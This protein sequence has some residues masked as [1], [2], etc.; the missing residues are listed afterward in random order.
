MRSA[1]VAL[2]QALQGGKVLEPV[3]AAHISP[4]CALDFASLY[5][6]IIMAH[7]LSY[8][9]LVRQDPRQHPA[10]AGQRVLSKLPV[11]HFNLDG[12]SDAQGTSDGKHPSPGV[13]ACFWRKGALGAE[14]GVLV[15]IVRRLVESRE[16]TLAL[17]REEIQQDV[18]VILHHR[19][20]AYKKSCNAM[21][22][23]VGSC[24]GKD[25]L[26]C[27]ALAATITAIGRELLAHTIT[28]IQQ[29]YSVAN[30]FH[31]D[32][33]VVYGDTDSVMVDFKLDSAWQ[34][35]ASSEEGCCRGCSSLPASRQC[36]KGECSRGTCD[37]IARAFA[38]GTQAAHLVTETLPT[39]ICLR[40][41]K[42]YSPLFLFEK[43]YYA[44]R[45]YTHDIH[46]AQNEVEVKG[47]VRRSSCR[48]V[49]NTILECFD[50][51]LKSD[52]SNGVNKDAAVQFASSKVALLIAGQVP[53]QDLVM[54][55]SLSRT[56]DKYKRR[57]DHVELAVRNQKCGVAYQVD[58]RVQFVRVLPGAGA[59]HEIEDPVLAVQKGLAID[60]SWY[61]QHQ[62]RE[63]LTHIFGLIVANPDR[64]IFG[65][66]P[67]APSQTVQRVDNAKHPSL[68]RLL[69]SGRD[70]APRC[71]KCEQ[72]ISDRKVKSA[73]TTPL[74]TSSLCASCAADGE[75][76]LM[77]VGSKML[78]AQHAA[79][80]LLSIC[81]GCT[82]EMRAQ[83]ELANL[84]CNSSCKTLYA[85]ARARIDIETSSAALHQLEG[86]LAGLSA[87]SAGANTDLHHS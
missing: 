16:Q 32:A 50:M 64:Q 48:F 73:Q 13:R 18:R 25:S 1:D 30:G 52:L 40:F 38:L 23:L 62:L 74:H 83:H 26:P 35:A 39:P 33:A 43:K 28:A 56:A 77:D 61:L 57:L 17:L 20:L 78:E 63:P 9:T 65:A 36:D 55:T 15:R 2:G 45:V 49:C 59:V 22:G 75:D 8:E 86:A 51:L 27:T 31:A 4:I 12:R 37:A 44:G 41:E 66:S 53:V 70:L 67:G 68:E 81:L 19:Q 21:Y 6:S 82:G 54:C 71:F 60:L 58:R 24:H 10:F 3:R 72:V 47:F 5:P 42:V 87:P 69:A 7:N 85:R 84:C 14:E 29:H 76:L 80:E 46:K 34:Q 11:E 79:D